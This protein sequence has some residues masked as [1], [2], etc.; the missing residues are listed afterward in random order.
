MF[1]FRLEALVA[2]VHLLVGALSLTSFG[3]GLLH[4][5]GGDWKRRLSPA[6][7]LVYFTVGQVSL[8]TYY[9]LRSLISHL[10]R[11]TS[12]LSLPISDYEL[13]LLPI[14]IL[15][16]GAYRGI[17]VVDAEVSGFRGPLRAAV[18]SELVLIWLIL[19][20]I[21][22]MELPRDIMLSSDPDLHAFWA[23]QVRRIGEVPWHQGLW[24]PDRFSYPSGFAVLNHIWTVFTGLNI[25]S[26]VTAQPLIQTQFS[27]G[28]IAWLATK[29]AIPQN[30]SCHYQITVCLLLVI[31]YTLL[32]YGYQVKHFHL[33]G[34]GR[35]SAS[36]YT[37]LSICSSL[38]FLF[39]HA[40][41]RISK[42]NVVPFFIFGGSVV[43]FLGLIN[44]ATLLIP[45]MIFG[46]AVLSYLACGPRAHL[47]NRSSLLFVLLIPISQTLLADPYYFDILRGTGT[48]STIAPIPMSISEGFHAVY[49]SLIS[50]HSAPTTVISSLF[51]LDLL[52]PTHSLSMWTALGLAYILS[53]LFVI[54]KYPHLPAFDLL[55]IG[56]LVILVVGCVTI[57]IPIAQ[58]LSTHPHGRLLT[59]YLKHS[60][61]QVSF[62][63]VLILTAVVIARLSALSTPLMSLM[64]VLGL[65][66]P[67]QRLRDASNLVNLKSRFAYSGSMGDFTE[68]DRKVL[69]FIRRFEQ[70]ILAK[71]P[72]LNHRSSPKILIPNTPAI[73]GPE[74]WLFSFGAA[75]V[76]PFQSKL[77]VAFFYSQ[78]NASLYSWDAYQQNVCE[79]LNRSWMRSHNIRFVFIPAQISGRCPLDLKSAISA[80]DILFRSGDASFAKLF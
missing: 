50:V 8:T 75:R 67:M 61:C 38:S 34:T 52:L 76:L 53:I 73:F 45:A 80:E 31:Y 23:T 55:I 11:Y 46:I 16:L 65:I 69:S 59:P 42:A 60:L 57:L 2:S 51:S 14:S 24:G 6:P 77:P 62:L 35:L 3:Y 63:V 32:P 22:L 19:L 12:G 44:P 15:A 41:R 27:L 49:E 25:S 4:L 5:A 70:E 39:E 18:V 36:L 72:N 43:S 26:I 56:T 78:G 21:S 28:I 1:T 33:E 9:Y 40:Q 79:G 30:E 13:W 20:V 71:Y 58:L 37:S 54:R 47:L 64:L 74:R 68:D 7:L 17:T 29:Y 10:L 48:A 66:V